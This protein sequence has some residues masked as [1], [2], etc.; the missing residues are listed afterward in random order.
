MTADG[1]IA[2]IDQGT[3]GTRCLLFDGSGESHGRAYR[4]HEQSYPREGWV[5]H[6]PLEIL[7]NTRGVVRDA[8]AESEWDPTDVAAIGLTNQRETTVVWEAATGDPVDPAIVWQDRRTADRVDELRAAGMADRIRETT[9]LEVDAYFSATK[10][11][12]LLDREDR[13]SRAR[14]GDLLLGTIDSWLLY[15]LTGRHVTDL[16]N[17]SRTMLFD[18]HACAWDDDLLGEFGIPRA[19]LPAVHPS[20]HPTAFGTTRLDGLFDDAVPVAGVLGDQQA[21]LF[22][23]TCVEPGQAKT[24]YGTGSF[25]LMNTGDEPVESDHGLLTTIAYGTPDGDVAYALEGSIFVTGAAIGWLADMGLVES[26]AETEALA[27]EVDTTDGVAFVPALQ[28]LGAPYWDPRAR[29]TIL[30]LSRRTKRAHVVRAAL[31]GIAH[32]TRDVT[33]AMVADAGIPLEVLRVDGG[34]AANDL[35]CQIQAD[36]LGARIA[37][38]AV[39]E[40]TALGAASAAGLAVGTWAATDD[41]QATWTADRRFEPTIDASEADARH[42]RWMDAIDRSRDWAER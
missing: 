23:Q 17:A 24:T 7:E 21:A 37:R 8:L 9:G 38:P 20:I 1:L 19:A 40:T 14:A 41:L 31:E 16:T 6:D 12:W 11:E 34:A 10:M 22:G 35:L 39:T 26:P 36:I 2:A 3:T 33:D 29:G 18:I 25:V 13:R 27:A 32:R 28:G 42:D 5:E 15:H 30:G 4:T